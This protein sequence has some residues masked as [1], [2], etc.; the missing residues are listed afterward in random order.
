MKRLMNLRMAAVCLVMVALLSSCKKDP[1]RGC[2]DSDA[3][4][5]KSSAEEDDGSCNYDVK[6]LFWQY[7]SD[8]QGKVNTNTTTL[9]YYIDGVYA[10]SSGAG[11]YVYYAPTECSSTAV[12]TTTKSLGHSK[13][14][15]VTVKVIDEDDYV[16]LNISASISGAFCTKVHM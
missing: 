10:G 13:T 4:N 14:K 6:F 11:Y 5:Y 7:Q 12:F 2:M 16:W 9:Y 1:I 3:T 8:A 15:T